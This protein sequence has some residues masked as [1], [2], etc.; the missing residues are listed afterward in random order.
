MSNFQKVSEKV[1]LIEQNVQNINCLKKRKKKKKMAESIL[2]STG[3]ADYNE[4]YI[5][6]F[7]QKS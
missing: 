2:F 5:F 1:Q 3:L 4:E 6:F 7:L